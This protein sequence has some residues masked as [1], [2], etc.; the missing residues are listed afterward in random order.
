MAKPAARRSPNQALLRIGCPQGR[1]RGQGTRGGRPAGLRQFLCRMWEVVDV[2]AGGA[3][4]V[5]R[6][7]GELGLW[8]RRSGGRRVRR[9]RFGRTIL[10]RCCCWRRCCRSGCRRAIWRISCPIW[11]S[12]A[13]LICPAVYGAYEEERGYPPYDPRLMVKLLVYGYANG[14]I[15][16]RKLERATYH[17]I[18]VRMLCAGQHPDYR[19]IA[20][21]RKRHLTALGELFVQTLRLCR[22]AELVGFG[23]LASTGRSCVR[24][25]LGTRR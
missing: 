13:R 19:S 21:F 10:I 15:S 16:S 8:S 7:R 23:S 3:G 5:G 2:G 11:S 20:R 9:R 14:V 12:R 4:A 18:A 25:L 6:G 17:D 22:Q 24:T 1:D